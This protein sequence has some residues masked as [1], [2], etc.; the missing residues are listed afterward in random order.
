MIS[1]QERGKHCVLESRHLSGLAPPMCVHVVLPQ[2]LSEGVQTLAL[3]WALSCRA[4]LRAATAVWLFQWADP[5]GASLPIASPNASRSGHAQL[6]W[7][8]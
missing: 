1:L 7:W 6:W 2:I 8:P 4:V 3:Y 5:V